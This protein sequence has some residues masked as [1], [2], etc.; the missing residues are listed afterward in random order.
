MPKKKK[1]SRT[2]NNESYN[3][4]NEK[5]KETSSTNQ[6][7]HDETT[8]SSINEVRL[9]PLEELSNTGFKILPIEISS[10]KTIFDSNS[11]D[12]STFTS[13][14]YCYFK[15]HESR[16]TNNDDNDKHL[17]LNSTLFI[18]NLPID[19]T[20]AHIKHLFQECGKIDR[21]IF[22]EVIKDDEFLTNIVNGSDNNEGENN[23]GLNENESIQQGKKSKKKKKRKPNMQ[24]GIEKN[25]IR[26]FEEG[27][28]R[29]L[30]IPDSSAHI[31]FQNS[32]GLKKALEMT[33][34]KRIWTIKDVVEIPSL[35]LSRWLQDYRLHR[36][37]QIKLQEEVDEYMRKFEEAELERHKALEAKLNQPD[38]DGFIMVTRVGRRSA[39]TDGTITVTAA[40]P[41]EIKNLK[42]KNKELTDFYRFQMRETKRNKLIDLRKKFE[43]DKEK[44]AKLKAARRFKPY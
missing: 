29:K 24:G 32:E 41:E 9:P 23:N 10:Q 17:P 35:G 19:S 5:Q 11:S 18:S 15:S 12:P 8:N 14:H 1:Q 13:I 21:I 2:T 39:N 38:E 25:V 34:K 37:G 28:L 7:I 30:L 27:G 26:N 36:P 6:Q 20:E 4:N 31:V 43:E 16:N 22:N 3:N 44:I 33:Q 40:K 42:P